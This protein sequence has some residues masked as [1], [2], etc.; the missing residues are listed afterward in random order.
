MKI[1][2]KKNTEYKRP[3]DTRNFAVLKIPKKYLWIPVVRVIITTFLKSKS[4]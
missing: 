3:N 2:N 1:E 4:P